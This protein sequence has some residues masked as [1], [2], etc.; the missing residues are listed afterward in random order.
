MQPLLESWRLVKFYR[1]NEGKMIPI[2]AARQILRELGIAE[3]EATLFRITRIC[4]QVRQTGWLDGK[5]S[6]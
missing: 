5:K 4:M 3:S 6:A 2:D 1:V